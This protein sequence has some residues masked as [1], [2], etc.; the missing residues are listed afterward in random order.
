MLDTFIWAAWQALFTYCRLLC[1][2]SLTNANKPI[3]TI[4]LLAFISRF[5]QDLSIKLQNGW[6]DEH[7]EANLKENLKK[8]KLSVLIGREREKERESHTV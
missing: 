8:R 2:L 6:I 3:Q 5:Y 1:H 7:F 4:K